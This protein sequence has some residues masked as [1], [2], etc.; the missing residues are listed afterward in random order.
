MRV[1]KETIVR[2]YVQDE[3]GWIYGGPFDT[4]KEA[5]TCLERY[6][7][8]RKA[9]IR[10]PFLDRPHA[11]VAYVDNPRGDCAL[12]GCPKGHQIHRETATQLNQRLGADIYPAK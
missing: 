5:Q 6:R 1:T 9:K 3:S 10:K 7:E 11:Y 2:Y 12:C 4:K 8:E